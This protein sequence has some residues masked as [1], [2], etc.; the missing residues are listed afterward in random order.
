MWWYANQMMIFIFFAPIYPTLPTGQL[1]IKLNPDL[2]GL[3]YSNNTLSLNTTDLMKLEE[4]PG[5]KSDMCEISSNK[6]CTDTPTVLN[7][8]NFMNETLENE[9]LINKTDLIEI[10][11]QSTQLKFK[12]SDSLIFDANLTDSNLSIASGNETSTLIA[13]TNIEINNSVS[14]LVTLQ[15][16]TQNDTSESENIPGPINDSTKMMQIKAASKVVR[17][18][19]SELKVNATGVNCVNDIYGLSEMKSDTEQMPSIINIILA[20]ER[21]S[22]K[23]NLRKLLEIVRDASSVLL[24]SFA[25]TAVSGNITL[26]GDNVTLVDSDTANSSSVFDNGN[27]CSKGWTYFPKTNSCYFVG[28]NSTSHRNALAEC[29]AHHAFLTSITNSDEMDFINGL[30][31]NDTYLIGLFKDDNQWFWID[32]NT[33]LNYTNWRKLEPNG[34][35]GVN[36]KCVAANWNGMTDGQWNDIDCEDSS[37]AN[38]VCKKKL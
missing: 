9:K 35:C 10:I 28:Q 22:I 37:P 14:K 13:S 34:C 3:S 18:L 29:S 5:N 24:Q 19:D 30:V 7:A 11:A 27:V 31:G 38:F 8:T 2:P 4:F 25:R 17:E 15:N 36:V 33:E 32:N 21:P 23:S 26:I 20:S 12:N 1:M 16:V 6:N